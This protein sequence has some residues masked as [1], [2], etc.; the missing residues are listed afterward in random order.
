MSATGLDV[1]DKT[2]QTTNIWLDEIMSELGPDRR[3]AWHALGS[4]LHALRDRLP[5]GLAIHLGAQLPIL[6]RGLYYDQW[7]ASEEALKQRSAQEFLD[8]VSQGLAHIRPVNVRQA[9]HAVFRVLD[10]YI[11]PN[12]IEKVRQALPENVRRIWGDQRGRVEPA[13]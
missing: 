3:V 8:H 4:V 11:D 7:R 6:V 5:I 2:L 9:T 12:Q 13:A 10:H 1:F